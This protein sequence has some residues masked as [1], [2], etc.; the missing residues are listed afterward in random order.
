VADDEDNEGGLSRR[1]LIQRAAA[2]SAVAWT[3][4]LIIDSFASP[5]AAATCGRGTFVV[6]YQGAL[7][8]A[9]VLPACTTTGTTATAASV[10]LIATGGPISHVASDTGNMNPVVLRIGGGCKC[11]ITSVR[12]HVHRRGAPSTPTDCPNPPCQVSSMTSTAFLLQSVALPATTVTV[13]PNYT[14]TTL[15]GVGIH[16]GSP[17]V[18]NGY[19]LVQV[20]CP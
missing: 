20:T 4:P 19:M 6:A 5:A 17:S 1:D 12:A 16:W 2:V 7:T 11:R 15:C 9:T 13:R 10:G 18:P 3:A 8:S 14:T